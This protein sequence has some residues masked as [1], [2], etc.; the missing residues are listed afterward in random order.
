[1]SLRVFSPATHFLSRNFSWVQLLSRLSADSERQQR[2][3]FVRALSCPWGEIRP[4]T[5]VPLGKHHLW[6]TE[7]F[8]LCPFKDLS[9]SENNNIGGHLRLARISPQFFFLNFSRPFGH[10]TIFLTI[11]CA[12]LLWFYGV[13][14]FKKKI[15]FLYLMKALT[16]FE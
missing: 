3:V 2:G 15:F 5:C 13:G 8:W 14:F 9:Q 11:S 10:S 12:G 6:C 4:T 16:S 1:M 7:M